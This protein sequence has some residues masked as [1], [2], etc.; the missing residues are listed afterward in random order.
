MIYS[1]ENAEKFNWASIS[2]KLNEERTS[3]LEKYVVGQKILDA[4]CGGGAYV[5]F[6]AQKGFQATGVDK[7]EEFLQV[8]RERQGL[9][10]YVKSDVTELPFPDKTFD[11][12]FSFDVFEHL[13]DV[14]AIK[15]LERVSRSRLIVAVPQEDT[16]FHEFGLTYCT[17][18]DP[19]HLRY[20]TED[21]LRSLA[22]TINCSRVEI[23]PEGIVPV[24]LLFERLLDKDL[25]KFP[26][27]SLRSFY[28]LSSRCSIINKTFH[29]LTD[30]ILE[31]L[32]QSNE[33][34]VIFGKNQ[35]NPNF[36][37][38]INL[39]LVMVVDL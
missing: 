13:D 35:A 28:R 7:Y 2:G 5:E 12:A 11:C 9:G 36:Y 38:T 10:V 23:F 4:G 37:K 6:F 21:S 26:S 20:Y 8:A 39:G 18:K 1:L 24:H 17:Y 33:I 34:E 15:E 16:I 3:Y 31:R 25:I 30:L 29:K 22:Q 14:L 27:G 19:T 32:L